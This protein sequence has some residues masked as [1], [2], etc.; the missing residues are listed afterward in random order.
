LVTNAVT[1]GRSIE[2]KQQLPGD[3]DDE[4]KE[5]L[6]DI[7]SFANTSGGDVIYGIMDKRNGNKTTGIPERVTGLAGINADLQIRRL[8]EIIR[9]G[10]DPRIPGFRIRAIEGFDTGPLLLIRIPKSW[11]SPHMV[12]FK[13]ASRFFARN[14]GGKYQLDVGEIRSAF[15]LSGESRAKIT[16]FRYDRVAKI[17]ANETPVKLAAESKIILHLVPFAILD[18]STQVDFR[19]LVNDSNLTRVRA[20]P[21]HRPRFN[22]DG[23]L[24]HELHP[25]QERP[26]DAYGWYVQVFR[27]G[28]FEAVTA[29]GMTTGTN[30]KL[31]QSDWAENIILDMLKRFTGAAKTLGV[32]TPIVVMAT[33]HGYKGFGIADNSPFHDP[34]S[35]LTIDRE[36]LLLPDVLLEDYGMSMDRLIRPVFDAFW[37]AAGYPFCQNYN[38]KGNWDARVRGT[39]AYSL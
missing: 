31:I 15:M 20:S 10:I 27:S 8:D 5:F 16:T 23:F 2:Y 38:A 17:I 3:T 14:T 35:Y 11:A 26:T 22:L 9:S 34:P 32:Q 21:Y 4:K 19:P 33:M 28:A 37:Q 12:K 6:A 1:E 36:T 25:I 18:P 13:N 29:F 24:N 7:S 30:V 39:M